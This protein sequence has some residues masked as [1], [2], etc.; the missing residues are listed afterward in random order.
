[1]SELSELIYETLKAFE[2]FKI[3]ILDDKDQYYQLSST[4]EKVK[5]E[6]LIISPPKFGEEDFDL[7]VGAEVSIVFY[8]SDGILYGHSKILAKQSGDGARLKI[9]LPYN[10]ELINRRRA[11]R[12]RIRIRA[13]IEYLINKNDTTKKVL[14]V[15]TNDINMYGISYFDTDPL[16]KYYSIKCKLHL[17]DDPDPVLAECKYIYSQKK[18]VRGHIMYKTALEFTKI[19]RESM[20]R[21]HQR[22]FRRI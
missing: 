22:C 11:K 5:T 20:R 7:P 1:M 15:G 17:E 16:G 13:E 19:S 18:M 6:Y 2:P 14:N 9:S 3:E 12:Y 10:V 4:I 21:I 8:R